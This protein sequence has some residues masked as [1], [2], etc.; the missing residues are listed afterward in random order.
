MLLSEAEDKNRIGAIGESVTYLAQ[1]KTL[2][3]WRR[4]PEEASCTGDRRNDVGR[5][6]QNPDRPLAVLHHRLHQGSY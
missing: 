6:R 3:K 5:V 2:C 4:W 1:S